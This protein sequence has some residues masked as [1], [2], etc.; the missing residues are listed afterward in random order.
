MPVDCH[1]L[2]PFAPITAAGSYAFYDLTI[3]TGDGKCHCKSVMIENPEDDWC[4]QVKT[5][6][7]VIWGWKVTPDEGDPGY[8]L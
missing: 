5:E 3:P 7:G 8:G 6:E 2:R 4:F 1:D